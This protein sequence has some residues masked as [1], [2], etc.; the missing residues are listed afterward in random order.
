MFALAALAL[1]FAAGAAWL[2]FRRGREPGLL[3]TGRSECIAAY[4]G[5]RTAVDSAMIDLRRPTTGAQK[6]HNAPTCGTMRQ[7]GG[8]R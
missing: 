5:A 1:S 4:R 2:S 7:V 8:M 6:D 3:S